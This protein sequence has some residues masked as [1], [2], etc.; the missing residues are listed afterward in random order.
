M[1]FPKPPLALVSKTLNPEE[2]S[3]GKN[4]RKDAVRVTLSIGTLKT[5]SH[6]QVLAF[7]RL[8]EDRNLLHLFASTSHFDK[9]KFHSFKRPT[10]MSKD[11]QLRSVKYDDITL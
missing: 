4:E 2:D 6:K 3:R 1:A 9:M 10:A 7:N 8:G 5:V 11:L